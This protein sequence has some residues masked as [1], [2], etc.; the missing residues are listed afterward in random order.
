MDQ[1]DAWLRTRIASLVAAAPTAPLPEVSRSPVT[2]PRRMRRLALAV[3]LGALLLA[4]I[5]AAGLPSLGRVDLQSQLDA[6]GVPTDAQIVAIQAD[7]DGRVLTVV[8]RDGGGKVHTIGGVDRP[9]TPAPG[10]R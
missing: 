6:M 3:T 10:H 9:A 8:Y 2:R 7:A 1:S 4:A 5:A